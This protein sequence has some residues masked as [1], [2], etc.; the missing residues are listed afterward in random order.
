MVIVEEE[1]GLVLFGQLYLEHDG[2][3]VATLGVLKSDLDVS[4]NGQYTEELAV[5]FF[6]GLMIEAM[7]YNPLLRLFEEWNLLP[8]STTFTEASG[9][10]IILL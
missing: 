2:P 3:V 1:E 6:N 5:C 10:P 9:H 4:L 8:A 7:Q